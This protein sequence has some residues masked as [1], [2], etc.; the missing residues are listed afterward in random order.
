MCNRD[1]SG[2]VRNVTGHG[3][4]QIGS[5]IDPWTTVNDA[6]SLFTARVTELRPGNLESLT[7]SCAQVSMICYTLE[8][9]RVHND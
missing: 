6:K 3:S 7:T 2:Q 8:R 9:I 1:G 4:D 5:E